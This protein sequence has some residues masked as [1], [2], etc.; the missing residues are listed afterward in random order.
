MTSSPARCPEIR[1][2][3]VVYLSTKQLHCFFLLADLQPAGAQKHIYHRICIPILF[4]IL[5]FGRMPKITRWSRAFTF[6]VISARLSSLLPRWTLAS[7]TL[8]SR[9]IFCHPFQSVVQREERTLVSAMHAYSHRIE[10]YNYLL[11]NTVL[12]PSIDSILLALFQHHVDPCDC[13]CFNPLISGV[14]VS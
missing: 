10:H 7:E 4:V 9:T 11:S 1:I 14:K 5:T 6:D 13:P 2:P 3:I 12:V 8:S